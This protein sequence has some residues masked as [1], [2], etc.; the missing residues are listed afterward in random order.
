M[1]L[2]SERRAFQPQDFTY[3]VVNVVKALAGREGVVWVD[4]L[5]STHGQEHSN[6]GAKGEECLRMKSQLRVIN[7]HLGQENKA[8][9]LLAE[10]RELFYK[11]TCAVT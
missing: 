2:H 11:H 4:V 10:R 1:A 9:S 6:G 5:E 3:R 7:G 8:V